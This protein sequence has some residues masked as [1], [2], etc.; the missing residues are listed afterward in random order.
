M[1]LAQQRRIIAVSAMLVFALGFL[2]HAKKGELPTARFL[3][4]TGGIFT[5]IS[6]FADLGMPIGAGMSVVVLLTA[7]LTEG[8]GAINL[9]THRAGESKKVKTAVN[10][11]RQ[12]IGPG[13]K[14][15]VQVGPGLNSNSV[16]PVLNPHAA[17][18]PSPYDYF[19]IPHFE[20]PK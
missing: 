12:T 4:G 7:T 5:L 18:P 14:Q 8:Q 6:I 16:N 9:L 19:A 2:S 15:K 10:T 1:N 11:M 20:A 13:V 3:I 17:G